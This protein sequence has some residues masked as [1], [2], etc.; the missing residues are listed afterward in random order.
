MK[1]IALCMIVLSLSINAQTKITYQNING[2]NVISL[3]LENLIEMTDMSVND[4]KK[5]MDNNYYS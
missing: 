4:W 1:M 3:T 5:V 2:V